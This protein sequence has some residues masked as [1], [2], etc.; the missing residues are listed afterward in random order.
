MN[1]AVHGLRVRYLVLG[2]TVPSR[3]LGASF[4]TLSSA[5]RLR[6]IPGSHL[7]ADMES[8]YAS[9]HEKDQLNGPGDARP[10]A[11][12]II[13]DNDLRDKLAGKV[14]LITGCSS[15]LGVE[16]ARALKSTGATIYVTV[17]DTTKGQ[18]ALADI[19]EQGRVEI[20]SLDLNS[21]ESVE[22]CA[23]DFLAKSSTLN[24]LINNAAIMG[25]PK[26][27]VTK[28]GFESQFQV[29][30]LSH[31]LLFQRLKPT[32]LSSATANF[33]SRVIN[34]AS[35][36][37]LKSP[38]HLDDLQLE[39]PDAYDPWIAYGHA[40]TA[41]VY[42]ANEIE[43]RYGSQ[44]LH[45]FSLHPGGIWTGLQVHMDVS[46]F[47]GNT[48]VE[49]GMKSIPQGAATT[50]WAAVDKDLKDRGGLYLDDCQIA[51][52]Q[53]QGSGSGHAKWAYDPEAEKRLWEESCK[54]LNLDDI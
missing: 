47:K 35:S 29:N 17:R 30:Y 28:D 40:K 4:R 10:T 44:N 16:T 50:I 33:P 11:Q 24:I 51:K 27:E 45:A 22:A 49:K 42:M 18:A 3:L 37:H 39:K 5:N 38:V 41:T 8:R 43:R 12:Q 34:V 21:L 26:R 1:A 23:R 9:V 31:F 13:D 36:G 15:G 7:E 53:G 25:V 19:L 48:D 14:A 52:P 54:L 6:S 2:I 32:L 20:L 46:K